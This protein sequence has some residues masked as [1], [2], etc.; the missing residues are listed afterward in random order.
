MKIAFL[1]DFGL[2]DWY[3]SSMKGVVYS[4]AEENNL[5]VEIIDI[6]HNIP[7][8]DIMSGAFA[9][10]ISY[11]YFPKG[12]VFCCV[13]DPGVGSKRD[14]IAV[15]SEGFYFVLPDNGLIT[16]ILRED[17]NIKAVRIENRKLMLKNI[18]KTFHGRDVFAPVSFYLGMKSDL[19][20]AGPEIRRED[21]VEC[22]FPN[23]NADISA[24][25][26]VK[27]VYIDRFGN[28]IL[29]LRNK[30]IND[31]KVLYKGVALPVFNSYEE[32]EKGLFLIEGS[33]G[34]A[35]ISVK[36]GSALEYTGM[37]VGDSLKVSL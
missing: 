3:V 37:K 20:I 2:K 8:Q 17:D 28:M 16:Y 21:I 26:E 29:N 5:P 7:P 4:L 15:L 12:T 32:A 30:N 11:R 23:L 31:I 9:L 14:A 22:D 10:Y 19:S 27:V 34:F 33:S 36:N 6:T 24:I 18:S 1:T 25:N 13:V 35:E